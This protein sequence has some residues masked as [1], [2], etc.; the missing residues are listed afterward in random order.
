MTTTIIVHDRRKTRRRMPRILY[1]DIG[2]FWARF[3]RP[4]LGV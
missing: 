4:A 2:D 3:V 1:I